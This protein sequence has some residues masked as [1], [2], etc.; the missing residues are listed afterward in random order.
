MTIG[1]NSECSTC[2]NRNECKNKGMPTLFGYPWYAKEEI[3]DAIHELSDIRAKYN[4]FNPKQ[5]PKYHACTLAIKALNSII[6]NEP[7]Q[8]IDE[9]KAYLS[10]PVKT[11]TS[12]ISKILTN[13]ERYIDENND[14]EFLMIPNDKAVGGVI[15][16]SVGVL[17]DEY[18]IVVEDDYLAEDFYQREGES[19]SQ[20]FLRAMDSSF[21]IDWGYYCASTK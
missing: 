14:V 8:F 13:P 10:R 5:R 19:L 2:I 21:E 9:N 7:K 1:F 3:Q 17:D 15:R 12:D 4:L 20:T 18:Y 11:I 16:F 6:N